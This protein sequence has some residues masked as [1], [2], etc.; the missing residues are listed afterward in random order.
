MIGILVRLAVLLSF[1]IFFGWVV[2]GFYLDAVVK[3]G[4]ERIGP[5]ITGTPVSV[6]RVNLSLVLGRGRV[7]GLR[8][9]NPSG[10]HTASAY[11]VPNV[12]ITFDPVSAISGKV[13]IDHLVVES[14]EI[15]YEINF[16][17]N[18]LDRISEHARAFVRKHRVERDGTDERA[19]AGEVKYVQIN[20]FMVKDPKLKVTASIL[21]GR[22][23]TFDMD[24]IHLRDIG[25][26]S[27]GATVDGA[28]SQI[29]AST[30]GAVRKVVSKSGE[31][32]TQNARRVEEGEKK[33]GMRRGGD[34]RAAQGLKQATDLLG[35]A[36]ISVRDALKHVFKKENHASG[37]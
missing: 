16:S 23:M 30:V 11:D 14:P 5:R 15:T 3:R 33:R 22:S 18:N 36:W 19:S 29:L 10:Y 32:L 13:I 28:T 7:R 25:K 1:L 34:E 31:V 8:I 37:K 2:G 26:D 35:N 20:H 24:E 27:R 9:G 21:K 6:E 17:G 4:L 12:R